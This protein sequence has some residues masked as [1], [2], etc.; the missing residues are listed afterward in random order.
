LLPTGLSL[1]ADGLLT[2][3]PTEVGTKNFEVKVTNS[4]GQ[5]VTKVLSI[6][7]R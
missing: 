5:G 6:T 7:V 2:G 4:G 3:S 1:A